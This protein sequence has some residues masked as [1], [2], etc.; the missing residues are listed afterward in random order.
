M[1]GVTQ[2]EALAIALAHDGVDASRDESIRVR[3][4]RLASER[5]TRQ[6]TEGRHHYQAVHS[7]P[8]SRFHPSVS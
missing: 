1:E 4:Q 5:G 8:L 6:E 3:E 7:R 2:A